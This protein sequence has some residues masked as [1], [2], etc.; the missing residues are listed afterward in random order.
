MAGRYRHEWTSRESVVIAKTGLVAL[1]PTVTV[2]LVVHAAKAAIVRVVL[3]ARVEIAARDLPAQMLLAVQR[4]A[5][6]AT[7]VDVPHGHA[8]GVMTHDR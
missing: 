5:S 1:A 3:V 4:A 6:I 7:A 8:L 2:V